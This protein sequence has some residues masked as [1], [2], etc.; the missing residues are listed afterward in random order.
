MLREGNILVCTKSIWSGTE[1]NSGVIFFSKGTTYKVENINVSNQR[2][3][4][5]DDHDTLRPISTYKKRSNSIFVYW[6][7]NFKCRE[8]ELS[9][10]LDE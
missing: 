2:L 9:K 7:D 5:T 3:F 10:L 1:E 6:E 8:V 4:I